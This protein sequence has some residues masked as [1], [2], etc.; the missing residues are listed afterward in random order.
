MHVSII[1]CLF[2]LVMFFL[3]LPLVH[4]ELVYSLKGAPY[5]DVAT[6]CCT[7]GYRGP[8]LDKRLSVWIQ[9]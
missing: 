2:L 1:S 3:S 6:F 5:H 4:A 8:A 7:Q 9:S